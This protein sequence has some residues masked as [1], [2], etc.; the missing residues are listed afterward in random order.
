MSISSKFLP[1]DLVSSG[2]WNVPLRPRIDH[3]KFQGHFLKD[4]IG[5]VV[6]VQQREHIFNISTYSV[7]VLLS[8]GDIG[9]VIEEYVYHFE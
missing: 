4:M 6:A 5:L 3:S 2:E 1:G 7:C 9:W 8:S